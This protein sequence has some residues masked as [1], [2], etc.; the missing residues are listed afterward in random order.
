MHQCNAAERAARTFKNQFIAVICTVDPCFPSYLW[1]RILT[2]VT[3]TLNML[4][5]S[6]LNPELSA[7]DQVDGIHNFEGKPLATLGCKV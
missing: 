7:Y 2:Q 1:Y 6:R 3:I 5:Q 4:W